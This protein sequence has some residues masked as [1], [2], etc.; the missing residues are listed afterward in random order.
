MKSVEQAGVNFILLSIFLTGCSSSTPQLQNGTVALQNDGGGI[1]LQC[2]KPREA[3]LNYL[4][5]VGPY[6]GTENKIGLKYMAQDIYCSDKFKDSKF[7]KGYV[8]I[9]GSSRI[10]EK[11]PECIFKDEETFQH[12]EVYRIA[13]DKIFSDVRKF[14]Y[15]WN[16]KYGE[17]YPIMTGAGPGLMMAG[18]L[19]AMDATHENSKLHSVGYTT[20]YDKPDKASG[21]CGNQDAP[22]DK[23]YCGNPAEAFTPYKSKIIQTDGLIFSSVVIREAA[24]IKHSAAI[25]L[26]PG[27]SGS[28][29]EIFQILETMKSKQLDNVPVYILGD[30]IHWASFTDRIKDM[31]KRG[32]IGS[33]KDLKFTEITSP[34]ELVKK[35]AI[36]L[37][38]IS[39]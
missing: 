11:S 16:S 1:E 18:S 3:A 32:T 31:E 2:P 9:F 13:N 34:E 6:L 28:E 30:S 5:Y 22:K 17:S 8:T 37:V 35:L 10:P 23:A 29:W 27:G 33:I 12:C 20:Y 21:K 19:G 15:L 36:D 26:A 4:S 7:R 39:K 25:V 24:M 38:T 14:A